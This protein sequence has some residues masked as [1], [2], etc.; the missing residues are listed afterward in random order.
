MKID[1]SGTECTV[2]ELLSN[3]LLDWVRCNN[4]TFQDLVIDIKTGVLGKDR[5]VAC[6]EGPYGYYFETD[7]YEG[8]DL[9]LLAVCPLDELGELKYKL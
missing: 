9:E 8:G 7:W 2:H 3:V 1:L 5:I 4:K 6:Y